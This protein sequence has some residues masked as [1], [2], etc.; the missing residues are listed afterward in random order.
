MCHLLPNIVAYHRA[1]HADKHESFLA[2]VNYE[3]PGKSSKVETT[4][5]LIDF[6]VSHLKS[7]QWSMKLTSF[8]DAVCF[9][10]F[11]K[12]SIF[13]NRNIFRNVLLFKEKLCNL[14]TFY[15]THFVEMKMFALFCR[16]KVHKVRY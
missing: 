15:K 3:S 12:V 6:R 1:V 5:F 11:V 14:I 16:A 7:I 2:I 13:T 10:Y 9:N 8:S 4:S